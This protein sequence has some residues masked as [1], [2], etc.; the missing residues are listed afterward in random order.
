MAKFTHLH[1]HSEYSLLD[2]LAKIDKLFAKALEM[3]MDSLALTDHG[4]MYGAVKFFLTAKEFEMKPIIG[5]EAYVAA[6]S[7]FDKQA[8]ID[9]DRYHLILLAKNE[10]GYLNLMKLTTLSNLEGFYYKPRIDM[11]ILKKYSEGLIVS[12]A[13]L[14]GEIPQLLLQ[15]QEKKAEEKAREFLEIFGKDFYLELQYH[16]KIEEYKKTNQGLVKLSQKLG[17]PLIATND[18]HYVEPDDAEAQDALLEWEKTVP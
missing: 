6:R 15:N 12:T 11:E 18:V 5:M 10:T 1:V 14:E 16:P 3:G 7:R 2:G 8:N 9:S 17:I 4:V 13:C